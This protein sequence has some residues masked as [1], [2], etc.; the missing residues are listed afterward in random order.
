MQVVYRHA[1]FLVS[2]SYYYHVQCDWGLNLT[3][4]LIQPTTSIWNPQSFKTANIQFVISDAQ[5][6]C[7]D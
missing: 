1:I 5:F 3:T 6:I 4:S 7:V 2:L